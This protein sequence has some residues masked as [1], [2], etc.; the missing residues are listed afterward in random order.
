[1]LAYEE[2]GKV[3]KSLADGTVSHHDLFLASSPL[4]SGRNYQLTI[5]PDRA[6]Y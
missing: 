4:Q 2:A 5:H 6:G 3:L 1:M